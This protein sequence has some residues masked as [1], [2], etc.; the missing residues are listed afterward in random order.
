MDK[1]GIDLGKFKSDVCVMKGPDQVSERFR[2]ETSREVLQRTFGNRPAAEVAIEA[3]RDSR[4]VHEVLTGLG[5]QVKVMDTTQAR[6]MGVGRGRRKT[7]RRDAEALARSL[8]TGAFPEAHV[9]S[10]HAAQLRDLLLMRRQLVGQRTALITELRG[11]FQAQGWRAPSCD[12]DEFVRRLRKT[13]HE[14]VRSIHVQA[15][16][17]MIEQLSLQI[18]VLEQQLRGLADRMEAYSILSTA[19][20]VKLIVALTFISV[21]DDPKR[22]HHADEV[23]AYLGF[24]PS[25]G[26][27]GEERSLGSI[28]KTGNAEARAMLVQAAWTTGRSRVHQNDPLVVWAKQLAARRGARIAAVGLGRRLARILWAMWRAGTCYDPKRVGHES[29]EGVAA[30]ARR[31]LKESNEIE[32]AARAA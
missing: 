8:W 19:P 17:A 21:I 23:A 27:T 10:S 18:G 11:Q 15:A 32:S 30:R 1:I 26:S 29:A 5:H 7:N 16:L 9:L 28:T 20:G 14:L 31:T 24:V 25:E 3:G 6:A 13:G 2:V 4:W 22:F 12:A